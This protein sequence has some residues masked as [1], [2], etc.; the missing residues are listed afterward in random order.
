MKVKINSQY[1][2]RAHCIKSFI[3]AIKNVRPILDI[4]NKKNLS[5]LVLCL[6]IT[7]A[8][9]NSSAKR[10]EKKSVS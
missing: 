5:I 6:W 4:K 1:V 7:H 9:S 10:G 8:T 3:M 2:S